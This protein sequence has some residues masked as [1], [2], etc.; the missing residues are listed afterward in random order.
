MIL[1][2]ME[3]SSEGEE[4]AAANSVAQVLGGIAHQGLRG[5]QAKLPRRS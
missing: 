4:N 3:L 5:G 1:V 2:L